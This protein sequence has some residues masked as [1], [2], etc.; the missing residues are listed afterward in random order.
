MGHSI[1]H[2]TDR[3]RSGACRSGMVTGVGMHMTKHVAAI[4]SASPGPI[5]LGDASSPMQRLDGPALDPDLTVM[6]HPDGPAVALAATV[7]HH[8]DGS[9]SHVVGIFETPEG[10]R[11]CG[12]SEHP[13]DVELVV[14][15]EWVGR[16]AQLGPRGDGTNALRW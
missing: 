5:R 4:W 8:A 12:T 9:P 10:A 16:K 1:S 3:V 6:D 7:V 15:D 13:D 11:C 2:L 14:G